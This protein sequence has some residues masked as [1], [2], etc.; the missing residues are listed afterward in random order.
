MS[1]R[2]TD[3]K[4]KQ[5]HG[6]F[7]DSSAKELKQTNKQTKS[8]AT[9]NN[10]ECDQSITLN[11]RKMERENKKAET[12]TRCG[13]NIHVCPMVL[14]V[15]IAKHSNIVAHGADTMFPKIFKNILC[16]QDTQYLLSAIKVARVASQ[17]LKNMLALAML[18]PHHRFELWINGKSC[19]V[20]WRRLKDGAR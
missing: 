20:V 14:P 8:L 3:T 10:D 4:P 19:V 13:D 2:A 5:S 15:R 12:K 1:I 18:P 9:Q 17:H 11:F 7:L 6:Y 16:V